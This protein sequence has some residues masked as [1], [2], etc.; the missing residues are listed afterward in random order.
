M[1]PVDQPLWTPESPS[2]IV[3]GDNLPVIRHLPDA[4]F[5]LIYLDPPFNTGKAQTRQSI[6]TTRS[7]GGTRIGFGGHS[8]ETVRGIV[9]GYNDAF[10]DYW[11]FLEPRLEEAWRLLAANGTLYLHLDYREVHY[12]K[13]LLD[14]LFGRECFL[15]EIIWAYDFGARTKRKWPSKHDTILVYVK[16]PGNYVFNADDVD[17]EPYMA[18]GLVTPEKVERGKLP[19]D[20]WWHTIVSPTGKEKTGYATQKPLGVLRRIVQASS[21]PGDWVLD[22]F[23]GSGTTGAAADDLGRRFLL[24]DEN[25]EA[26]TVMRSRLPHAQFVVGG[27]PPAVHSQG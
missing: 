18:P 21:N 19:T 25:P 3:Q 14:A 24:I 13:V 26:I 17:R 2:T 15:N 4:S 22:F 5:R 9:L 7:A 23:A 1:D 27:D 10:V 6:V 8:Y 11:A 16:S 12:A 20:V